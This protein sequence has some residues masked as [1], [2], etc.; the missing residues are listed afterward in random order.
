MRRSRL[1]WNAGVLRR[2]PAFFPRRSEGSAFIRDPAPD[3]SASKRALR[4]RSINPARYP[5]SSRPF[6]SCAHSNTAPRLPLPLCA[7]PAGS[8]RS[9]RQ[10]PQTSSPAQPVRT[11]LHGRSTSARLSRSCRRRVFVTQLNGQQ[12]W[13]ALHPLRCA[14]RL[15]AQRGLILQRVD[16]RHTRGR[17][18][19]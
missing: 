4:T 15:L 11:A 2:T 12:L 1:D 19:S 14:R 3:Y 16:R 17:I 5:A 7:N 18:R 13:R 9:R 8:F 10:R 6:D